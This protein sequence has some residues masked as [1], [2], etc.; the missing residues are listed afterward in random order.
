MF[1]SI[2]RAVGEMSIS[3]AVMPKASISR[4]AFDLVSSE[5]AKPGK[6]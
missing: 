3:S 1:S 6:V 5:V 4:Q 2:S